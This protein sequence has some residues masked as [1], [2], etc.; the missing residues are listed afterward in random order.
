[1]AV[2]DLVTEDYGF[3]YRGFAFGGSTADSLLAPGAGGFFDSANISTNDRERLRRHGVH[4][5]D[6][7][8]GGK[9]LLIPIEVTADTTTEWEAELLALKTAMRVDHERGEDALVFQLP[10]IAGGGKRIINCRPRGLAVPIDFDWFYEI[11]IVIA[12]FFSTKPFIYDSTLSETASAILT[13]SSSGLTWPLTW[14]LNW[15]TSSATSFN[16]TNAGTDDAEWS[17]IIPG[18]VTNPTILHVTSGRSY[19]WN[20]AL[21]AGEW[22]EI[23]SDARTVLLNGTASRYSTKVNGSEWF[24]LSP[25]ANELSYRADSGTST[26]SISH[27]STWS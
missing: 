12:R 15:G 22:L 20:I 14:P 11:P 8:Y 2:G 27:R 3:E 17:A 9:E 5:G 4:A 19:G 26:L 25:G 23:D 24:T 6:D 7:F 10:G 16:V 21:A 13:P 1:M 18:P